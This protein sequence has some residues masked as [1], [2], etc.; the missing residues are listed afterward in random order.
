MGRLFVAAVIIDMVYEI[1]VFRWMAGS[2]MSVRSVGS[3]QHTFGA[4]APL[5]AL[6]QEFGFTADNVVATVKSLLH[7]KAV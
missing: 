2:A 1:I 3:R 5:K 4:S 7:R 6:Q